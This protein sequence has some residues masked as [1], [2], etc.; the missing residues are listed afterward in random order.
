MYWRACRTPHIRP[1]SLSLSIHHY[2]HRD[3]ERRAKQ[4][5]RSPSIA[6]DVQGAK[7]LTVGRKKSQ[8]HRS[9]EHSQVGVPDLPSVCA[10]SA[11][12]FAVLCYLNRNIGSTGISNPMDRCAR[13]V[14]TTERAREGNLFSSPVSSYPT[15]RSISLPLVSLIS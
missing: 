1:L 11:G 4:I 15:S 8:Q 10:L 2:H 3:A 13:G 12:V 9:Q 5:V 6:S 14:Y 7:L